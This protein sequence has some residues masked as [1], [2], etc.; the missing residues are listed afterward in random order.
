MLNKSSINNR[1]ASARSGDAKKISTVTKK[2]RAS[3][4]Q[5]TV[6]GA[7]NAGGGIARSESAPKKSRGKDPG[8]KPTNKKERRVVSG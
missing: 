3:N 4:N 5:G 6:Y 8:R 1:G 7:R 2:G